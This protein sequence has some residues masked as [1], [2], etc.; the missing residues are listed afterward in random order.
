MG[1]G[2]A[3]Q[4]VLIWVDDF[5]SLGSANRRRML[6]EYLGGKPT[7]D[8]GN[9]G[10][11]VF[12]SVKFK[13]DPDDFTLLGMNYHQDNEGM[14][15]SLPAYQ[16]EIVADLGLTDA[17]PATFPYR[18]ASLVLS[19][20]R[21]ELEAGLGGK[22]TELV[23]PIEQKKYALAVAKLLY[24]TQRTRPDIRF[25]VSLL[26]TR[27]STA[28][29]CDMEDLYH[30]GRYLV[31]TPLLGVRIAPSNM[32][33]QGSADASH[34][35]YTDSKGQTGVVFWLGEEQNAPVL[36]FCRKHELI[37][38]G[39]M[40]AEIVAL[41]SGT[42]MAH[43][44]RAVLLTLECIQPGPTRIEQDNQSLLK[45]LLRGHYTGSSRHLKLRFDF[46]LQQIALGEVCVHYIPSMEV[47]ADF[48]T[49]PMTN[50]FLAWRARILNE[51]GPETLMALMLQLNEWSL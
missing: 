49:K 5:V 45:T 1:E 18:H 12:Q 47:L 38:T 28:R 3:L 37:V 33:L 43:R 30:L 14:L 46:V 29:L 51:F 8:G 15:V 19:G 31:G 17:K 44:M 48:L 35:L 22:A 23:S 11:G 6:R 21:Q 7:A 16:R 26:S 32:I 24:L 4:I 50:G 20:P 2:V 27:Q 42:K 34:L 9:D 40:E 25:T 36:V 39:S 10:S 13:V 41:A